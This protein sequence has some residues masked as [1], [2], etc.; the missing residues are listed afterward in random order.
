MHGD[1]DLIDQ[2]S[3]HVQMPS[4]YLFIV[5]SNQ[6]ERTVDSSVLMITSSIEEPQKWL[7]CNLYGF[8]NTNYTSTWKVLSKFEALQ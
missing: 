8:R 6:A 2:L 4:L 1:S 3:F 5:P 7:M